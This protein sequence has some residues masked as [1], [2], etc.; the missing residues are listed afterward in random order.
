MTTVADA[1]GALLDTNVLVYAFDKESP[2][3]HREPWSF[4]RPTVRGTSVYARLRRF[5]P[6]S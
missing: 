2:F 1:N 4:A 6:S 5:S 3:Q